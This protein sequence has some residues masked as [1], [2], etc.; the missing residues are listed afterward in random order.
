MTL[1]HVPKAH[2]YAGTTIWTGAGAGMRGYDDYSREWSFAQSGKPLVRGSADV[3]FR[4]DAT[5]T[6]PEDLLLCALSTCHMLSWLA[7]CARAGI[8]VQSYRDDATG[9]MSFHAGKMRFTDVLLR[10]VAR[11]GAGDP[12]QAIE[13][14]AAAHASCFIASSV[15]FD[16]RHEARIEG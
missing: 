8:A 1:P 12:M 11:L 16:V 4:G 13:L 2:R 15:N 6:N 3:P 5:L 9:T 10:P 14:H 7:L